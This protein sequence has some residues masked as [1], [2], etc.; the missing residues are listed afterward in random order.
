MAEKVLEAAVGRKPRSVASPSPSHASIVR[1]RLQCAGRAEDGDDD[2]DGGEGVGGCSGG[3]RGR[4][5]VQ[6]RLLPG[7]R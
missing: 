3:A 2:A 1:R 7:P 4:G 6:I 5:E